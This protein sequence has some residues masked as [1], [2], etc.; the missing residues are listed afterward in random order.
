MKKALKIVG[1]AIL[2]IIILLVSA[3]FVFESQLKDLLR[4]TINNNVNA[5]V[6]FA[7]VD[8]SM[9]RSFPQ[10]TLVIDDLSIVNNEP[11]KGDTLATSDEVILE[12]SVKELFKSADEPK[13]IDQLK[14]NNA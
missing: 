5:Q 11:F 2:V 1:F 6:A 9:F 13:K 14:F 3:P 12:M 8:L 7:D 10:A 4:K